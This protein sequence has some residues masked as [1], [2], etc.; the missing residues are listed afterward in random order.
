MDNTPKPM[1]RIMHKT[2]SMNIYLKKN[3]H[4]SKVFCRFAINFKT[5]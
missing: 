1:K 3:L 2:E 5:N 4:N